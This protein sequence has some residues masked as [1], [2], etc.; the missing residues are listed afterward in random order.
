VGVQCHPERTE[1]SPPAF[2]RLWS[3]FVDA[4]GRVARGAPRRSP[5]AGTAASE[6]R[7]AR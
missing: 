1:F 4:A 5:A 3:A 7:A 6:P 2:E